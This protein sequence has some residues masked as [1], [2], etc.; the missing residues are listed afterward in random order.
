MYQSRVHDIE[1]LLDIWRG[2]QQSAVDRQ[3]MEHVFV[4]AYRPKEDTLSNS[5]NS[6]L[7]E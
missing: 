4:L 2:L 1:K 5:C 6:M 3:L 7:I